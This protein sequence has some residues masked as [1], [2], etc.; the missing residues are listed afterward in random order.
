MVANYFKIAWRNLFRNKIYS[1]INISGI[2]LGI[3]IFWLLSLYVADELSFD[4][5][6][7]KANRIYRVAHHARWDGGSISQASTSAPFAAALKSEFPEIQ[8]ATRILREGGGIVRFNDKSI[9]ADDI[10]F[11]D[12]NIFNVFTYPFIAGDAA[13]AL[14]SPEAIVLTESLARTLFTDPQK[15]INQTIHFENNYPNLVTGVIKDIPENAH[16]RFSA[17]RSLPSNFTS[18]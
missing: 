16:L 1:L 18:G 2:A 7:E 3:A 9:K 10:L 12:A 5:Y 15:A 14:A 11:A 8:E 4:R 13:K 17:L 6:H